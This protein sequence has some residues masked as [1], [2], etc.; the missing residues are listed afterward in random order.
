M[1]KNEQA[2]FCPGGILSYTHGAKMCFPGEAM[3]AFKMFYYRF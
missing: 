2:G 1:Y 3:F